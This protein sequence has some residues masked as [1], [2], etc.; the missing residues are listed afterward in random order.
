MVCPWAALVAAR[1]TQKTVQELF[2]GSR[3]FTHH[4]DISFTQFAPHQITLGPKLGE[5]GF[6]IVSQCT[7]TT[8]TTKPQ[9]TEDSGKD[10]GVAA[11]EKEEEEEEEEKREESDDLEDD[12][13][14]HSATTTTTTATTTKTLELAI[15]YLR[16]RAMVDYHHFKHGAADLAVEAYFLQTLSHRNI[17]QLHGIAAGS[18]QANI[19]SR[20]GGLGGCFLVLDRLVETLEQR[21]DGWKKQD[22]TAPLLAPSSANHH[23]K[24]H[25]TTAASNTTN[26]LNLKGPFTARSI[27][28]QQQQLTTTPRIRRP[29]STWMSTWTMS[30]ATMWSNMI[31]NTASNVVWARRRSS[32]AAASSSGFCIQGATTNNNNNNN[33]H[34]ATTAATTTAFSFWM[35][36]R[37]GLPHRRRRRPAGGTAG[38]GTRV[39]T[40]LFGAATWTRQAKRA[41]L[42]ERLEIALEVAHAMAYLHSLSVMFRD[43]KPSNI[44]F[45]TEGTLKLFDFGL[46][47]EIKG[48][49]GTYRLTGHTGSRRYMVRK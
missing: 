40:S 44:G 33:N 1:T 30:L 10:T 22:V 19:L 41:Q 36:R 32:P 26:T 47:K 3:L 46:A 12:V 23:N 18:M 25:R 4:D 35:K 6:S 28:Q 21:I 13:D 37:G 31:R 38:T 5:G 34:L 20:N 45:N 8:T 29:G 49:P 24:H 2:V 11:N 27:N 39:V 15:K 48:P 9:E 14:S 17:I 43:L 7:V 42:R 16:R